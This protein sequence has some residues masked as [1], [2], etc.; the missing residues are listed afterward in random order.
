M[1]VTI[2][3]GRLKINEEELAGYIRE[4]S[5]GNEAALEQFYNDYGRMI[6]A[7]ILSSVR[8]KESAEEVLQDVLLAL[9]THKPDKTIKNA[10]AWL[11]KV[12]RNLSHKKAMEDIVRQTEKLPDKE[13][14]SSEETVFQS[15]ENAVDQIEALRGLDSVEQE[16][17]ILHV[18]GDMK[19]PQVAQ[20]LGM[21]YHKVRN[22]Y[23]YAVKKLKQYYEKR[24]KPS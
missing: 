10:T 4:I 16:C 17:V 19:L 9:V 13:E 12:I 15:V 11:F 18:F 14:I 2:P 8:S 5:A 24:R 7:F 6:M 21:P 23:N 1:G 20:L 22:K 3:L